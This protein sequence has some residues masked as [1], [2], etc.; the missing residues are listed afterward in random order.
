MKRPEQKTEIKTIA[1]KNRIIENIIGALLSKDRFLLLGHDNPDED[2]IAAMVA[3]GLL[4]SRLDKTCYILTCSEI[5]EN[6][7]YLL[8]ICRY[9]SII[10]IE[11][12]AELPGGVGGLVIMDTAKPSMLP[13]SEKLH[14]LYEDE[15]VLKIEFDHHLGSDSGYIGDEGYCLVTGASS[16]SELVGLLAF[17][18]RC[19]EK[20]P[21]SLRQ[22]NLM[23]R[24]FVLAVLTGI[25]GDSKMGK[26]LK[27]KREQWFY[28]LFSGLF[29]EI[30]LKETFK[31]SKNFSTMEQVYGEI[32]KLSKAEENCHALFL[33]R[34]KAGKTLRWSVLGK[35]ES[36]RAM[37]EF[38]QETVT[39]IS[40]TVADELAEKTKV[41]GLVGFYDDPAHS[42]F[43]QF[44]LRRSQHYKGLDLRNVL[45][46]LK[47]EN[48]GG[49]EGAVGFRI[50]RD[51]VDNID[52]YAENIIEKLEERLHESGNR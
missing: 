22:E 8:N 6:Y 45:E 42:D 52:R 38:G 32:F 25:I 19:H 15:T 4:A 23:T 43:I 31:D 17:K 41:M 33:D 14:E 11:N 20:L 40:R 18:L 16:S 26:Y 46:M 12:C 30:L 50:E 34:M 7:R 35:E 9:N 51:R 44:R 24:N 2:C 29:E 1:G 39:A 10:T 37:G 28:R 13:K 36:V 21:A 27:S 3:F 48:G 47:I 5:N 49:H